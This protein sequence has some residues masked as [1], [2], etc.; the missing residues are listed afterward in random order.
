MTR[1][2]IISA[3]HSLSDPG[4]ISDGVTEASLTMKYRDALVKKLRDNGY[5]VITPTDDL[6]LRQTIKEAKA[7]P[8]TLAIELH[9]NAF[10]R[11][12]HGVEAFYTR[13]DYLSLEVAKA[14][15]KASEKHLGLRN[16][17]AKTSNQSHRRR[18]GFTDELNHGVLLEI[19]FMDNPKDIQKVS[20]IERWAEV[21]FSAIDSVLKKNK[22]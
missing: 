2:I 15:L 17:G 12:A 18:L 4:A 14:L 3:G 22:N 11:E 16:R 21:M 13:A 7:F 9:F 1:D 20:D 6:S 8:K 5:R 19:C 10:N